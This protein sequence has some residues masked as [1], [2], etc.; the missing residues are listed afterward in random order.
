M[1]RIPSFSSPFLLGFEEIE[2]ALDRVAK[3]ADGYP[4]YNVQQL[5][6]NEL[7]ITLAVAGFRRDQLD[8]T[9]EDNQLIIRGRQ[10]DAWVLERD[11]AG[12]IVSMR[13]YWGDANMR[14]R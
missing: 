8:I 2:Q 5:G 9:L 14:D 11:D 1:S 13:A 7:R 4:P 12:L 10:E 6:E 3:A